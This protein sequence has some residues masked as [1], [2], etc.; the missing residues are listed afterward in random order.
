[1]AGDAF[2]EVT[3]EV[4]GAEAAF[5]LTVGAFERGG[6][7]DV[8]EHSEE[9][10]DATGGD[11]VDGAGAKGVDTDASGAEIDGEVADDGFEG[12]FG[13]AHDVV[14]AD[15]AGG[16][17]VAKGENGGVFVEEGFE[18]LGGGDEAV[19]GDVEGGGE[20][21]SAGVDEAAFEVFFVGEG[22]GVD[23]EIDVAEE[24]FDFAGE[25][26]HVFFIGE[27]DDERGDAVF[28]FDKFFDAPEHFVVLGADADFGP[29]GVEG[30][31]DSPT[32]GVFVGDV[33][34]EAFFALE[35]H[36]R[37]LPVAERFSGWGV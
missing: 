25:G 23:E 22:G 14:V 5:F 36:G 10:G 8:L 1:M 6:L 28:A 34:D 11:G 26:G 17:E 9:A 37:R 21:F 32:D 16:A 35:K 2:G 31:D 27:I 13:D 7:S 30:F 12:G 33:E 20:A 24:G 15:G 3:T 29:L 19:G 18:S 4:D